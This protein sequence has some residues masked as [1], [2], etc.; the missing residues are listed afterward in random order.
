MLLKLIREVN[1]VNFVYHQRDCCIFPQSDLRHTFQVIKNFPA[2]DPFLRPN[3]NE[4]CGNYSNNLTIIVPLSR[5]D[6]E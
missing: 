4:F 3:H 6:M 5:R 2:L 1:T